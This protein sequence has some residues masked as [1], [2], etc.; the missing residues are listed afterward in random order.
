MNKNEH[1]IQNYE[2]FQITVLHVKQLVYAHNSAQIHINTYFFTP[3]NYISFYNI[4]PNGDVIQ[5]N[6]IFVGVLQ[7]KYL[8]RK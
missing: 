2:H 8:Q 3:K 5:S 6:A 7:R 4:T 1:K